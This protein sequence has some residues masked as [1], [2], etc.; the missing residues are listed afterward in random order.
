MSK[1]QPVLVIAGPTAVGKTALSIALANRFQGEIVNGDSMQIYQ[2]LQIGTATPT[3]AEQA[4][5]PHHL[6]SFRAVD[7][8]YSVAEF[9]RDATQAIAAIHAQ[10]HLPI[11]VGGTGLYL[12][13]LLYEFTLGGRASH[14]HFRQTMQAIADE[15]GASVLHHWLSVVDPASAA[16]IHPH[17]VRR[18]IRALEVATYNE[19]LLSA[20]S[21][22]DRAQSLRYDPL[23]IV[24]NTERSLLY[25]RINQRVD[26]M[27]DA[28]L[29]EE[30]KWLYD[31]QLPETAAAM[32]A[33]GY[34]ELF[35]YLEGQEPL[36]VGEDRLKQA[37][38]RY[39]KRQLTWLRHR[40]P[41]SVE[42]DLVLHPEQLSDLI[43]RVAT[44]LKER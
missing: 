37:S 19:T 21:D 23:V 20:Q 5:A 28:G 15:Q 32:Q 2:H 34:K 42:Y 41:H 36:A 31:K 25:E 26:T 43:A 11:V 18:V 12:Q 22:A 3:A 35:P 27:L 24:L 4:S 1:K 39:A 33:I 6:L 40:L 29:L 38:R 30:A 9:Q 44:F 7:E 16:A 14:P 17:N 13:A 8:P 10:H